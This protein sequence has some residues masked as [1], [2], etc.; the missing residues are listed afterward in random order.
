VRVG[1]STRANDLVFPLIALVAGC[2][3]RTDLAPL[4]GADA[5]AAADAA[6]GA[7]AA[8]D[9]AAAPACTWSVVGPAERVSGDPAVPGDVALMDAVPSIGGALVAWRTAGD[10]MQPQT[11]ILRLISFDPA[12]SGNEHLILRAPD[13]VHTVDDVS[14]AVG[15]GHAGIVGTTG[16]VCSFHPITVDGASNGGTVVADARSCAGLTDTESGF[17]LLVAQL[18][19]GMRAEIAITAL[20]SSGLPSGTFATLFRAAGLGGQ[21]GPPARATF[22]D[23]SFL[24]LIV[25]G[26]TLV[27]QQF[28]STGTPLA[29]EVAV[30]D[31]PYDFADYAVTRTRA[32]ALTAA[33]SELGI[34]WRLTVRA[35]ARDG[36]RAPGSV[37]FDVAGYA[38]TL[39]TDPNGGALLGWI[40]ATTTANVLWLDEL[41]RPHGAS[42]ALAGTLAEAAFAPVIRVV[43]IGRQALAIFEARTPTTPHR[44]Y[45]VRLACAP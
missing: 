9:A 21:L 43:A 3:A 22:D 6:A 20:D 33:V 42:I 4:A 45:A 12:M 19:D 41:G 11:V 14:L 1:R 31:A 35:V 24:A 15:H 27:A 30:T 37:P 26:S 40:T 16:S 5:A 13:V 8:A 28:S 17:D 10:K 44:V 34:D 7:D 2:G 23:G 25:R 36:T 29:A 32:G 18:R 39:V 38:P